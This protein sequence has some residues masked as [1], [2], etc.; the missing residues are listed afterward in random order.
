MASPPDAVAVN[1]AHLTALGA[2]QNPYSSFDNQTN[3]LASDVLIKYTWYGDANLSGNVDGTDYTQIDSAFGSTLTGWANGD[4]NYDKHIDGSDYTLID[5]AFNLQGGAIPAATS[6]SMIATSTAVT[7]GN[8]VSG[9][10]SLS[11]NMGVR[12]LARQGAGCSAADVSD[13]AARVDLGDVERVGAAGDRG[14]AGEPQSGLLK[15]GRRAAHGCVQ[16]SLCQ[17][18]PRDRLLDLLGEEF[19]ARRCRGR[20]FFAL[21]WRGRI[22]DLAHGSEFHETMI[23]S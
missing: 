5:N 8:R 22:H 16:L 6:L 17:D 21:D 12:H 1:A 14:R 10:L 11:G 23:D 7:T 3:L 9:M 18:R 4:F 20:S 15:D 19:D 2:I 13:L